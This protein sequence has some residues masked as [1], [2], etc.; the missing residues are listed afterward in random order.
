[1]AIAK[2]V[3]RATSWSF[4]NVASPVMK[5][6]AGGAAGRMALGGIVGGLYGAVTN[7]Y[8]NGNGTAGWI[9]RHAAYGAAIGGLS[10]L[11]TPSVRIVEEAGKRRLATSGMPL[12]FRG[13]KSAGKG[14]GS[15]ASMAMTGAGIAMAHPAA[16]VG[17]IGGLM[18]LNSFQYDPQSSPI[19]NNRARASVSTIA[20][21]NEQNMIDQ[22]N[23][24][25]QPAGG[26]MG[27][28]SLRA[29][30]L[31][32]STFGLTQGLHAGRHS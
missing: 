28:S 26:M 15:L 7:P 13:A 22:M 2:Q 30:R 16:T 1:M 24:G 9:A 8:N 19:A 5:M 17:V 31:Y 18:A 6:A 11:V 12:L 21:Q 10:R 25:I 23:A 4:M 20:I 29:Q 32:Q 27:G 3:A 14:A